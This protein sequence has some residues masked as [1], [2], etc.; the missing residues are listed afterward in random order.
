[1]KPTALKKTLITLSALCFTMFAHAADYPTKNIQGIIQ[2]GTGGSTDTVMRSV[3]PEAEK[4]LGR[5]VILTNRSGGVGVI[6]TKYVNARK[7]DGYTLLMGAENPQLYKVL[8][9]GDTDYSDMVPISVLAQGLSIFVAQNDAP[10]N[11]LKELVEYAKAHPNEV[12]VGSTGP[13]G[14]PS[15]LL[16]ILKS[17]DKFDVT[18][19]PYQG[20]GPAL[21]ALL[22]GALDVMPAVYGAAQE[23]IRSGQI[24]VIG[25]MD[26]KPSAHIPDVKPVTEYYPQLAPQLPYSPFFGIWVKKGTPEDA[27]QKLAKAFNTSAESPEFKELLEKRGYIYLGLQGDDANEYLE[28]FRSI[29]SWIAYDSGVAKYSPEKFGIKK[30]T[31]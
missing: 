2:W 3:T 21:T 8:G 30:I 22:G 1:M 28:K 4:I 16:S 19:V 17:A 13:G 29:S 18:S 25:V 31:E 9:L 23:Y 24:K 15:V 12:K 11:N 27:V 14:L 26:T 10:Y 7:A 20:D 6:A 5:D